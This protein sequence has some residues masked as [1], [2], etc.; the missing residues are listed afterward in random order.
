MC[1][2]M[3]SDSGYDLTLYPN[4]ARYRTPQRDINDNTHNK[5][6]CPAP[7]NNNNNNNNN[8]YSYSYSYSYTA[9]GP[10]PINS[11]YQPP[12]QSDNTYHHHTAYGP[13][14]INNPYQPP[15]HY[16]PQEGDAQREDDDEDDEEEFPMRRQTTTTP[17][18]ATTPSTRKLALP[19]ISVRLYASDI[20]LFGDEWRR[21]PACLGGKVC[22]VRGRCIEDGRRVK[23]LFW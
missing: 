1:G 18:R 14:P 16:Q 17:T 9:Y 6:Y 12:N 20:L 13:D 10:D 11:P 2:L 21:C 4:L 5:T 15:N 19:T 3:P 7:D 8:S 23:V 22:F